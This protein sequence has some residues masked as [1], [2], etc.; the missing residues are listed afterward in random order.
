[1]ADAISPTNS[2]STTAFFPR[3]NRGIFAVNELPD[4]A[5]KIQVASS[6]SCRKATFRLR[7]TRCASRSTYSSSHRQSEDYTARENHHPAQGPIGAEIRTH[8][9]ASVEEE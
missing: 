5:G 4:L 7:A 1:V 3:A 6:T 2:P 8:Y 9:P